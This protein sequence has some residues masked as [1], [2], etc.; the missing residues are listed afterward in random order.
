MSSVS[1]IYLEQGCARFSKPGSGE[2]PSQLNPLGR[3][4]SEF[5]RF[6]EQHPD[7]GTP[8]TL[9]KNVLITLIA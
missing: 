4:T 2:H 7:R 6:A 9:F 5:M 3:V 1:A 8:C